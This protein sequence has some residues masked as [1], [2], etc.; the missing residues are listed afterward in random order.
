MTYINFLDIVSVI[1]RKMERLVLNNNIAIKVRKLRPE[2]K[3][4]LQWAQP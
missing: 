1:I 2:Q 3:G 4:I